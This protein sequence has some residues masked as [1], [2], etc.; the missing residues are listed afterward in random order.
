MKWIS[1]KDRSPDIYT[2]INC[3]GVAGHNTCRSSAVCVAKHFDDRDEYEYK[4]Y[5][6]DSI[7]K[8]VTHWMPMLKPPNGQTDAG[9]NKGKGR[10]CECCGINE[11]FAF[12]KYCEDC[13]KNKLSQ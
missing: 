1:V 3:F 9:E 2:I 8:N 4:I 13:M 7:M 10:I 12:L 6:T 5:G 11:R